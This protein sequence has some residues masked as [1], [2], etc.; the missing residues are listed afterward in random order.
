MCSLK[1]LSRN[2]T[3]YCPVCGNDQF[4]SLDEQFENLMDADESVR[5]KC[6]DCGRVISKDELLEENQDVINANIEEIE[7]EAVKEIEKE[8]EKALKKW[9]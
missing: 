6:S 4:E 8:L 7:K 3:L 9:K 2:V 5:F 1:D